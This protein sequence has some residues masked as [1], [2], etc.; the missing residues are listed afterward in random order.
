MEPVAIALDILQGQ[1]ALKGQPLFGM[2][3]LIPVI[4]GLKCKYEDMLAAHNSLK[5]ELSYCLTLAE[6]I[7]A[8]IKKRY[9]FLID[10]NIAIVQF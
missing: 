8:G 4:G 9:A 1:G 2:G 5:R 10:V 7:L 3:Y 6:V